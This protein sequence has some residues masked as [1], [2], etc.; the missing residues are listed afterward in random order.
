[1]NTTIKNIM[2]LVDSVGVVST[3][4]FYDQLRESMPAQ[5]DQ[6]SSMTPSGDVLEFIS[7][8]YL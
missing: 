8:K 5:Y 4:K 3:V 2:N 1:M 7:E 6:L